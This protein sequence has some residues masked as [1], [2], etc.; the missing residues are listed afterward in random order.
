M[1]LNVNKTNVHP[2]YFARLELTSHPNFLNALYVHVLAVGV[3]V[4]L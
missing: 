1:R 4:A 3:K 2:N